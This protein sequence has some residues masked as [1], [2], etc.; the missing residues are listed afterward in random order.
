MTFATIALLFAA[1]VAEERFIDW[2]REPCTEAVASV[3]PAAKPIDN[4]P[5]LL[6]GTPPRP[7]AEIVTA[8]TGPDGAIWLAAPQGVMR[9]NKGDDRWR[10]FHSRRWLPPGDVRNLRIADDG[11]IVE[12]DAGRSMI[13]SVETTLADKMDVVERRLRAHHLRDGFVGSIEL[14]EPGDITGGYSQPSD[15][16]DGLWTCL[17]VA[18]ESFRYAA[19]GEEEAR[20]NAAESLAALMRLEQVTGLPGFFA[21]SILPGDQPDPTARYGGQWSR[22]PDGKVW[23]KGDTSSDE[24]DGHY[25]AFSIY[26]DLVADEKERAAIAG[27]VGRLTDHILAH[28]LQYFGPDGRRTTWGVWDPADLNHN[29]QWI[30]ERGLNS[31]EILSHLAVAYHVTGDDRYAARARELVETHAYDTNTI[32]QKLL[33]P[34]DVNHSDDELAFLAYYPLL[35]YERDADRRAKYLAS[36]QRSWQIER[37]EKSPFYNLIYAA[38][39]QSSR[40][41]DPKVRP[42]HPLVDPHEY[43]QAACLAWFRDVPVDTICWTVR[44]SDRADA[45]SEGRDRRGRA[46]SKS[47]LPP[48]ERAVMKWNGDPYVLDDGN[49]GRTRDDGTFILLPYWLG[50]YH[51]LIGD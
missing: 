39:L 12:T 4:L 1:A 32:Y 10:L 51:R 46:I 40:Q 48:C 15:D 45:Q 20:R 49:D 16:N 26:Y 28:D 35:K 18:A 19:T 5:Q 6:A 42:T 8:A 21:R 27:V 3:A 38:G 17:Y 2:R 37:P 25:F 41:G 14:T 30:A 33:W 9:W 7:F 24:V 43:D 29:L 34:E 22:S 11:M 13:R 50:R 36:L 44:N 31:L 23:W 47:V